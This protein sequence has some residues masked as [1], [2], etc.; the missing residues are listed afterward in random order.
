MNR[1]RLAARLLATFLGELEEQLA[2]MNADLLALE[3]N[4]GDADRTKALFRA[5]HTLKG[6]ARAAGV[7]V[8]EQ[9]C[10]ALEA[11]LAEARD[12]ARALDAQEF[13]MLFT[14]VDALGDAGKRLRA[15]QDPLGE[16]LASLLARF[17]GATGPGPRGPVPASRAPAVPE[18]GDDQVRIE[19]EKLDALLAAAG[20]L[21]AAGARVEAR[22]GDVAALHAETRRRATE[23]RHV[24][25]R[26]R[27]ALEHLAPAPAGAQAAAAVE[28]GLTHL[29]QET[30]RLASLAA[31]DARTLGHATAELM[32]RA[33]RL[34]MRPFADACEALPR[35]V[36]DLA[37]AAGKEVEIAVTGGDVQADR[38]VLDGLREAL[39]HLVRNAVDHGI[40]PPA[41]RERAG[42]PRRGAVRIS[43]T[44]RG[45][46]LVVVT[47]DDG[48][49]LDLGLVRAQ[50]ERR[51]LPIPATERD[52]ARML[53]LGGVTTRAQPT[54]ISGRG[55]GLDLVRAAIDRLG[56]SID[57]A[58]TPGAGTTFTLE[59]PLS[60][61]TVRAILVNVGTQTLAIPT[62]YVERLL[63]VR[64]R[65]VKHAEGGAVIATPSA[66]VPLVSLARLLPPLPEVPAGDPI[67]VVL[68]AAGEQRLAV[69]V[70][71]LVA[72]QEIVVHP[73]DAG[74]RQ[75]PYLSGGALLGTGRVALALSP[76]ALI[77]AA[78]E[79]GV[80]GGV[81]LT[82]ETGTP[83]PVKRRLLV[84]D[85]SITT[86]TLEQSILE[87]AGYDVRTAVDGAEA[88]AV[89][90]DQGCDLL[91][92]DVEMPRMDGFELCEAIRGSK[93]FKELPIVLVTAM[94][95]PQH[96]ARGLEVGADAYIGKS[97][98]D[99]HGLLDVIRQLLA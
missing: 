22:Q 74:G 25:R 82:A 24:S 12:G 95:T 30:G 10:H 33:R 55:V 42:K 5:A 71:E 89:L 72:E 11:R 81:P 59:C 16:P 64:L 52:I 34:R 15:G 58:W 57:V 66:P 7:P 36:R 46:R 75:P 26:L 50:L 13:T 9:A 37:T 88:W 39:L 19:V 90:Q 80:R 21:L 69:A 14:A 8:I 40:E 43:A 18:R 45:D 73:L 84:V 41:G 47:G 44:L 78:L 61:A 93:R 85:D 92:A 77:A 68:L 53:F 62:S 29:A 70:N 35:M 76:P 2:A 54:V 51:G 28:H 99:Q 38:A 67:P 60:L 31:E 20:Q 27:L 83:K 97:S 79:S 49:G 94:E 96:R 17:G 4:R 86:R 3:A 32:D 6:A 56:G 63:R 87:A 1:D 91:V 65:D 23:W 48:A 98:F